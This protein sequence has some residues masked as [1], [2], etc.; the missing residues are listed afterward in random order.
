[1]LLLL[2]G[3]SFRALQ[4]ETGVQLSQLFRLAAHLVYWRKARVVH[5]LTKA[6][7]YALKPDAAR[8]RAQHRFQRRVAGDQVV[9]RGG[10]PG[11]R[12][13]DSL[14]VLCGKFARVFP[15]FRLPETIERF[16]TP[17]PLAE[18]MSLF[19]PTLQVDFVNAVV[20]L[21]RH[22]L[23]VQLHVYVYLLIDDV[24]LLPS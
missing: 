20:W 5:M 16:A 7:V 18:H 15:S 19:S 21:L 22:D 14:S 17:K 9:L 6:N 24:N 8:W 3:R 12:K 4:L 23:L 11:H 13:K 2:F 1:M 10:G